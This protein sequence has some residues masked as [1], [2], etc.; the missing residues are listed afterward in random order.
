MSRN[1][2]SRSCK[3]WRGQGGPAFDDTKTETSDRTV[4]VPDWL[5]NALRLLRK[6]HLEERLRSGLCEK[7][8]A[9]RY[10]HCKKW[11]DWNLAFAQENGKP[12][13]GRDVTQ[14]DLKQLCQRA[15]VPPI[16]FHDLG[17]LHNTILMRKN[18]NAG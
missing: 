18:V 16:R 2:R 7:G 4:L 10:Q 6:R 14:R 9:C 11:H 8:Q 13:R 3:T 15:G 1:T 5:I 17:H 12:L